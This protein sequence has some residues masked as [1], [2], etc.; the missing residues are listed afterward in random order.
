MQSSTVA[1]I[2]WITSKWDKHTYCSDGHQL[3]KVMNVDMNKHSVE[4]RQNL[5]AH[6]HKVLGKWSACSEEEVNIN[7]ASMC[8]WMYI[9][10]CI[11]LNKYYTVYIFSQMPHETMLQ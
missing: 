1:C 4:T 11:D 8:V 2:E 7:S 10:Y 9:L 5:L 6:A 3:V